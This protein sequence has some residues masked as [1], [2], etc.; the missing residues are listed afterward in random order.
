M[1]RF[2]P[3]M[4]AAPVVFSMI[5]PGV[6]AHEAAAIAS[7]ILV[8]AGERDVVPDLRAEAGAYAACTDLTLVEIPTMA[9]MHNMAGTRQLLWDRLHRWGE[10]ILAR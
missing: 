4:P 5:T 10:S 6:V 2:T 7:P 8:A 9:H 1:T 3:M